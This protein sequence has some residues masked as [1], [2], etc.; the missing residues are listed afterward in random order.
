MKAYQ[1]LVEEASSL[2][3]PVRLSEDCVSGEVG[4]ALLTVEGNIYTGVS[5]S[6]ACG[7]GFCGEHSAVA[8]MLKHRE[9]RIKAIVAVGSNR[10]IIPPCGRCRELIYQVNPANKVTD[11]IVAED[12]VDKLDILLP[13]RWQ[14][15]P[16]DQG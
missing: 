14:E 11:V 13:N 8:E 3:D 5:I 1:R 4:S 6:C 7:I 12:E 10:R 2:A 16:R 9:S 15:S